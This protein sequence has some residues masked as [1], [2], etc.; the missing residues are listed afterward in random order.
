MSIS[1]L[2]FSVDGLG[3]MEDA[4]CADIDPELFTIDPGRM[5]NPYAQATCRRCPVREECLTYAYDRGLTAGL[6][7][8]LS[9]G[10]RKSLSLAEALEFIAS[11]PPA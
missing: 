8:G 3:W 5:P 1:E 6:Y 7:G 11:D 4:A 10:Q 9:A 2:P